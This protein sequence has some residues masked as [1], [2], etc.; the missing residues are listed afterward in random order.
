MED[1][2]IRRK[3]DCIVTISNLLEKNIT[4][5]ID[6]MNTTDWEKGPEDVLNGKVIPAGKTEKYHLCCYDTR[7]RCWFQMNNQYGKDFRLGMTE[8]EL[9][10]NDSDKQ[11]KKESRTE[12]YIERNI[13]VVI[14]ISTPVTGE[15]SLSITYAYM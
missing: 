4:M 15:Y 5:D 14:E 13:K 8:I 2:S 10:T 12:Y 6:D 1:L 11:A 3:T 7:T 9:K